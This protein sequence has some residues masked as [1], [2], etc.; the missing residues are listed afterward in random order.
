MPQIPLVDVKAQ[1]AP[2]IPD[3][4]ARFREVLEDGRFVRGP[5]YWAF[6]EEAA[7][8]LGVKKSIGVANGTD[9]IVIVLDAME[10]G[11]GDE[12]ICPAFTFYATAE[13]IARRGAAPVFAD[14]DPVTM[15]LDV[16]DVAAKITSRTRALMPVHLFGRPAP[17]ADLV[18][19]GVPVIEDA[20]QAFGAPGVATQ[21]LVS[22]YS[23]YPT[24]NLFCVG[25]GGL[26]ASND[27]ELADRVQ[28]LS[29]HGSRDKT[30]FDFVGYNSRLDELQAGM[31]RIFLTQLDGWN[32]GR[33]EAAARYAELGLGDLVEIPQDEPG[34]IYHLFVC[35]SPERDRIRAALTEAGIA[36]AV[37]YTT[38]LHLQPALRFLGNEAGTLPHTEL[39]AGENFSV[40]LW[41]GIPVETQ[42]RVV[43]VVRS[44]VAVGARA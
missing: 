4:E 8:Y 17:I 29:F 3:L 21:G 14:I 22:T 41:P 34:H 39:I 33:R 2:L 1:Y 28:M 26:V 10:I 35:R 15:N 40:P 23:F 37:Y 32:R 44:A 25:D 19:L 9:A 36:S 24:K 13:S 12:V 11:P 30:E 38:P 7:A 27:E 43:D 18:S 20:A 31:L 6:Q 16:E 42:E 5:H